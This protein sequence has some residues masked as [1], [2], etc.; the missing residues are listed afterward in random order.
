MILWSLRLINIVYR[1]NGMGIVIKI[2]GSIKQL[3]HS[4]QTES[5]I[6]KYGITTCDGM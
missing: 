6:L 5:C 1:Q 2:E 4:V 3:C